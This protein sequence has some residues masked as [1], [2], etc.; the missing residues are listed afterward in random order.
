MQFALFYEIPVARPWNETQRVAGLPEH[1]RASGVRRQ[2]GFDAFWTVEHHFLEEYS[3]CS[4]PEVL[5]GAVAARDEEHA[6]RLRRAAAAEAV[7]PSR[8][9]GRVGRG[10]RPDL[11]RP[12]RLR[13]RAL[14]P[15]PSSRASASTPPTPARCGREA[16][17]HIVGCWT[18]D[19]YEFEGK[20]WSMPKRRV[21]PKPMQKPHPPVWGATGSP[22][23]A[24]PRRPD[25]PR[26]A[27]RS[28]S[29]RRPRSSRSA[30]TSTARASRS[31]SSRSAHFVNNQR[32]RLHDGQLRADEGGDRTRSRASR[33]SGTPSTARS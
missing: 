30:S 2:M 3:H 17:D 24:S 18:N 12:R 28:R 33:S 6:H 16:L 31:A 25:G 5:Y 15:A 4:N 32:L 10:A 13:H 7:Q 8:A 27:A 29:A 14:R 11:R 1:P 21:L 26:A 22:E 19:E 20:H 23:D 9:L